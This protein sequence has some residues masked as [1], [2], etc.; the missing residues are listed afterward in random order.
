MQD[1]E[2]GIIRLSAHVKDLLNI[3]DGLSKDD[4]TVKTFPPSL[5]YNLAK[6]DELVFLP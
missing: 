3:L 4:G 5:R 1:N 2:E 6:F